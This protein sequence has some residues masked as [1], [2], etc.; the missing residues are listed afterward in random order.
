MIDVKFFNMNLKKHVILRL[1]GKPS[2][3][4]CICLTKHDNSKKHYRVL[5]S[6]EMTDRGIDCSEGLEELENIP[7]GIEEIT[8][9][10]FSDFEKF[11]LSVSDEYRVYYAF[12]IGENGGV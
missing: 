3:G 1:N 8:I 7:D 9:Q 4:D 6:E 2:P 12:P 10:E 11:T 5:N